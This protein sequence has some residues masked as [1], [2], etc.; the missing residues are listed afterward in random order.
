MARQPSNTF[1]SPPGGCVW[2]AASPSPTPAGATQARAP[3]T[4]IASFPTIATFGN[5]Q[6]PMPNRQEAKNWPSRSTAGHN[7]YARTVVDL[8]RIIR[9]AARRAGKTRWLKCANK[10]EIPGGSGPD[11]PP[12]EGGTH[13]PAGRPGRA[14]RRRQ[15]WL[16][17]DF[18]KSTNTLYLYI[19]RAKLS[20]RPA[21]VDG[22][23]VNIISHGST[24]ARTRACSD[25]TPRPDAL[26]RALSRL[27]AVSDQAH[28]NVTHCQI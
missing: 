17:P 7:T 19:L 21:Q 9:N 10:M 26:Y 16:Y 12:P 4:V 6:R 27:D 8:G 22:I 20:V 2:P 5:G 3:G 23:Y 1:D 24:P 28:V 25:T 11:D 18:P 13:G 14:P 15:F